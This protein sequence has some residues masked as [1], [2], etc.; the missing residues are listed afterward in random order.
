VN[1]KG[2]KGILSHSTQTGKVFSKEIS[3]RVR[4]VAC[5]SR[6][7]N[8]LTSENPEETIG[9]YTWKKILSAVNAESKDS[10]VLVWGDEEDAATGVQEIIL[11]AREALIGVPGETRQAL[12]DGTNGFER[13]L[14]GP[15]RMY[16]DTDLPP[17]EIT[18]ERIEGLSKNLPKPLW[19]RE[20][21]YRQVLV[22]E[23]QIRQIIKSPRAA[24]FDRLLEKYKFKPARMADVFFEKVKRWERNKLQVAKISDSDWILFF[25]YAVRQPEILED[26]DHIFTEYL[27]NQN[28]NLKEIL[29]KYLP[30]AVQDNDVNQLIG[31]ALD[32]EVDKIKEENKQHRFIMGKVM[33]SC[34]G[35]MA[36]KKVSILVWQGLRERGRNERCI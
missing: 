15:D 35:H 1:L 9:S 6:L 24:L 7:P 23:H 25:D 5:L 18:S 28:F 14:P 21:Q 20:S 19:E 17:L 16:P 30:P 29:D 34:R 10:Q 3:D 11:R 22:P 31:Q 27:G 26:S 12:A 4:V 8:I 2:Y 32:E 13:I 36:G 33:E